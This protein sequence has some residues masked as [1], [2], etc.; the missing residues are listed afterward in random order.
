MG[1]KVKDLHAGEAYGSMDHTHIDFNGFTCYNEEQTDGQ[2]TDFA[3][4]FCCPVDEDKT[5]EN[6]V[7]GI[8][9]W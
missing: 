7:C 1:V 5:C 2:C 8:N 9:E 4:S 6:V 3:V